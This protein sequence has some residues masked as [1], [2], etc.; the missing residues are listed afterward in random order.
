MSYK[1]KATFAEGVTLDE[2]Y[3][4]IAG[5]GIGPDNPAPGNISHESH[6]ENGRAVFI[7]EW[8]SKAAFE[9]FISQRAFPAHEQAG[10]PTPIIEEI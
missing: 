2:L 10:L 8:E 3:Q 4:M 7:E 6:M 9:T 1:I 5:M